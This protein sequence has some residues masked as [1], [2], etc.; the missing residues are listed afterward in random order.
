VNYFQ[1]FGLDSQFNLD[2]KTLAQTY[3]NLQR[4]VHPDRFAHG[5]EQ[6]KL[7]AV[8]KS[9]LINDAYQTLKNPIRRAEYML[10]L[11]N[12]D[13]PNE[14][15]SFSDNSFLMRQMELREM[16]AEVKHAD[17]IDAAVG[18]VTQV[19]ESEFEQLFKTMQ[20]QLN[21]NTEVA[22]TLACENLRK[23]KFYQKLHVELDKL[24]DLLFDD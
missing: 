12:V 8:K 19:L 16:L 2:T 1:L 6:E 14:Q 9:T 11:R 17:D 4:A 10:E 15:M 3:Q 13:M 7:L 22:N 21:E 23:L 20:T 18:E 24:E 5:S